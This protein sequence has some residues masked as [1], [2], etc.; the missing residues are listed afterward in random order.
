VFDSDATNI[1]RIT[2]LKSG[3]ESTARTAESMY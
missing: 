2:N 1:G 3:G